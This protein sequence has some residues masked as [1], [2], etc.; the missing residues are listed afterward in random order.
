[1]TGACE[2]SFQRTRFADV[3]STSMKAEIK[4]P[5]AKLVEA[6]GE[7]EKFDGSGGSFNE[8]QFKGPGGVYVI[9]DYNRDGSKGKKPYPWH[10]GAKVDDPELFLAWLGTRLRSKRLS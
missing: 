1:M 5:Y 10:V 3:S 4:A 7:P 2:D 8:W 6:L 9:Y